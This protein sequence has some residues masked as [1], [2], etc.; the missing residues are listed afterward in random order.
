MR[1]TVQLPEDI[2]RRIDSLVERSN[3]SRDQIVEDALAQGRSLAWQEQWVAGVL[4]GLAQADRGD[5]A[6]DAD[7]EAVLNRYDAP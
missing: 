7:I 4:E 1:N 3:L 6:D 2:S 5:F